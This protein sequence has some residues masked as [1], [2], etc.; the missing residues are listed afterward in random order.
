MT[1][2]ELLLAISDML[3]KKIK[4]L[5]DDIHFLKLQNENEVLPRLQNIEGCYISTYDRY[6]SGVEQIDSLQN[7]VDVMKRVVIDHS[8]KLQNIS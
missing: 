4:P 6:K 5:K 8:Q 7:D 1:D 3:D 2:Q